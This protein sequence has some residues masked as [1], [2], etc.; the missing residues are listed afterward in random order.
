[1][2]APL[3]Q[4][5]RVFAP[6]APRVAE[7]LTPDT[8]NLLAD[9]HALFEPQRQERLAARRKAQERFDRGELPDF[10]PQTRPMR[11]SSWSVRPAPEDLRRRWVEITGPVERKMMVNA[12]NSGADCFMADFEDANSPTWS[13][14]IAGQAN[15]SD[16]VQGKLQLTTPEGKHYAVGADPATLIV[17]PRGW[18]L[19]EAH[20]TVAGAALSASL[21]DAALFVSAN[22]KA[23]REKGS[24]P[25]LYLPK[26]EHHLEARLWNDALLYLEGRV[27]L[28]FNSVRVTVLIETLPAAFQMEEILYELRDRIVGL[29]AGRWDYLFSTIKTLRTHSDRVLPDRGTVTMTAP[30]MRAYAKLLVAT[31]H[32]RGAHAMGGMAAFIPNRRDAAV[33]ERALRKVREDKERE[34]TD[35]FDG[36]WVAHPDLV[37]VARAIFERNLKGADNQLGRRTTLVR[38]PAALL[39]LRV[40]GAAV[41]ED[42]IRHNLRA[43]LLYME[44][45]L[46]GIGA[47]AIDNLMEDAATAEISRA[48]VWQWVHHKVALPDGRVVDAVLV[49]RLLAEERAR[50]EAQGLP[51]DNRLPE[52]AELL[53]TVALSPELPAFLTL[54]A[55]GRLE[56]QGP[57]FQPHQPDPPSPGFPSPPVGDQE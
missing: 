2:A 1:M 51:K 46:R 15:L 56:R 13:N 34:S 52:A 9:V 48:Q 47:V 35:G 37:P 33:T 20:V 31:C 17:R 39:D 50:I 12:F 24:G 43:A 57:S 41:T 21:F 49:D 29:N 45:W 53:A 42:G 16:F 27:G 10:L 4:T 6:P 14:C 54:P 19:D 8:L 3:Q 11:E 5:A 26:M 40:A 22:G 36:T 18:H 25:Y 44:A 32:K 38:D 55:Y 28:P 23:L 7:V 30:F